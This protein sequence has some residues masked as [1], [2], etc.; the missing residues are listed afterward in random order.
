MLN[1]LLESRA[2]RGR[3]AAGTIASAAAHTALIGAAV[4]ATAQAR[5]Q[6]PKPVNADHAVYF[7]PTRP[8]AQ[9]QPS[10]AVV[11]RILRNPVSFVAPEIK[12]SIPPINLVSPDVGSQDFHRGSDVITLSGGQNPGSVN[13]DAT[14]RADQ[15]E[16]EVSLISGSAPPK[17]PET[18][19][20]AGV[21]GRVV[22]RFVVNE[23]GRVEE[24]TVKFPRSDS[25]LF[26]EA[27]RLALVRMRFTP[28]EIGGK[29]VRQLV[30]M[31][32]VFSLSR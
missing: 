21:E 1:T 30:E 23:E 9:S 22:A 5:V 15:V 20:A 6:V 19:R 27:A 2:N 18:L 16:K 25:R 26:E 29:R 28:A 13:A 14:F 10:P 12:A 11:R 31:P 32:F 24:E 17:Y 7:A 3:S 8:S 4:Y